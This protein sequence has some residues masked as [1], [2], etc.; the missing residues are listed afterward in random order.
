MAFSRRPVLRQLSHPVHRRPASRSRHAHFTPPSPSP[1]TTG[2]GYPPNPYSVPPVP[3]AN[4]IPYPPDDIYHPP[5][6]TTLPHWEPP[7]RQPVQPQ[8]QAAPHGHYPSQVQAGTSMA[9]FLAS[10]DLQ[11]RAYSHLLSQMLAQAQVPHPTLTQ[12][13]FATAQQAPVAP[14]APLQGAG[15]AQAQGFTQTQ[16]AAQT[17]IAPVQTPIPVPAPTQVPGFAQATGF[18]PTPGFVQLPGFAQVPGG[19]QLPLSVQVPVSVQL[20]TPYTGP[21][22]QIPLPDGPTILPELAVNSPSLVNWSISD[23]A[24]VNLPAYP[25]GSPEPRAVLPDMIRIEIT[26]DRPPDRSL[27]GA[28]HPILVHARYP[29]TWVT[30]KDLLEGVSSHFAEPLKVNYGNLPENNRAEIRDNMVRRLAATPRPSALTP[31]R[32]DAMRGQLKFKGFS[33]TDMNGSSCTLHMS[34]GY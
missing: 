26:Y 30:W 24:P 19:A 2:F 17:P 27:H 7:P 4:P 15:F 13:A 20:P 1:A 32:A 23:S 16:A 3:Q 11:M 12:P 34:L 21:T 25:A 31:I 18:A 14:P 29:E 5:T 33:I 6:R 28:F 10:L 22:N 9:P 8:L